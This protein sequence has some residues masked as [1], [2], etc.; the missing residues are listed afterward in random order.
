VD[1]GSCVVVGGAA[2]ASVWV[3]LVTFGV[4]VIGPAGG[5]TPVDKGLVVEEVCPKV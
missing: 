5:G 3:E 4:I 2:G 1:V